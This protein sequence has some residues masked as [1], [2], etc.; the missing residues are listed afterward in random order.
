MGAEFVSG[1]VCQGPSLL[2]AEMSRNPNRQGW[3]SYCPAG[4]YQW[5]MPAWQ[6]LQKSRVKKLAF[7]NKINLKTC[8]IKKLTTVF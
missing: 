8:E 4:K 6:I 7:M 3:D 2:G 5:K 1:R